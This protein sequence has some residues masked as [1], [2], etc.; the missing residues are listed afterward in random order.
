MIEDT[1]NRTHLAKLL[2]FVSSNGQLTSL[3]EYVERMKD[4]QENIFYMA[5]GSK[6]KVEKSRPVAAKARKAEQTKRFEP[7]IGEDALNDHI[8][9]AEI[10]E[11]L[12]ESP[13]A[14]I[15]SK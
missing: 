3:A 10:S 1:A 12:T 8:L 7:W 13:C 4:K 15:T 6:D 11:R 14:L 2:F 9:R 5:G